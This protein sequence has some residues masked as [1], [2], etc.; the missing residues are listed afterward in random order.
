MSS[1]TPIDAELA[2]KIGQMLL[3]GFRG[4]DLR[5]DPSIAQDIQQYHLGGVILFDSDLT[6]HQPGRNI[7]DPDQVR[8]LTHSLH[9]LSSRPLFVAIDQEGGKVSRLQARAGFSPTV[10]A[11]ELGQRNQPAATRASAEATATT[12]ADLGFNLNFAPVVD[13]NINP[14]CPAIGALGRSFS[15]DPAIVTSHALEWIRAHHARGVLCALKHFPGHGSARQD[16]HLG[17]VDVT[18]TWSAD[19]LLPYVRIMEAG[20]CDMIM[21]AHIFHAGLEPDY[22]AT[23]SYKILTG[24]LRQQ[25][26]YDGVVISDD[27]QMQAISSHYD[28]ETAI[29]LAI[30]GGVDML[31]FGNNL[32]YERDLPGRIVEILTG[33]VSRG[34]ISPARIDRSYR[35]IRRLQ[36]R[37]ECLG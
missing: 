12:L 7:R 34:A 23:L 6:T 21:T 27:L 35:R 16:S 8:R 14:A 37:L 22:P 29:E 1:L 30:K 13:L 5:D 32:V 3:V 15:S 31:L 36:H 11:A 28:L 24:L 10:S 2:E 20:L 26:G 25:L 33:L 9:Q 18:E 17:W 4:L 19:E